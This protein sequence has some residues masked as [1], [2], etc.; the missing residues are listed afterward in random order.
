[1]A[2]APLAWHA[3]GYRRWAAWSTTDDR[4]SPF[5]FELKIRGLGTKLEIRDVRR[6]RLAPMALPLVEIWFQHREWTEGEM[7]AWVETIRPLLPTCDPDGQEWTG[8][9]LRAS[10]EANARRPMRCYFAHVFPFNAAESTPCQC[11][12][13]TK[14]FYEAM[15]RREETANP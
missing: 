3:H 10:H 12:R 7:F 15:R 11:Q 8:D 4:F 13:V 2:D 6:G 1:V 14:G 5:A 9:E